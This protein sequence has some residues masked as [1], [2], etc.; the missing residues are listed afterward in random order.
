[1]DDQRQRDSN[2]NGYTSSKHVI[3]KCPPSNP[4]SP[5][6]PP[7]SLIGH[8]FLTLETLDDSTHDTE[9]DKGEH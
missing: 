8:V 2:G 4:S 7:Y 1:M 3:T 5:L 9:H 6:T